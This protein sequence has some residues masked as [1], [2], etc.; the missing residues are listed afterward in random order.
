VV[1]FDAAS[2]EGFG[3]ASGR[4]IWVLLGSI[5]GCLSRRRTTIRNGTVN[6]WSNDKKLYIPKNQPII[7]GNG[8]GYL[9][10]QPPLQFSRNAPTCSHAVGNI[11]G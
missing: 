7:K 2:E 5:L 8:S 1:G 4:L 9:Y 11:P 10:P 6:Q 3:C